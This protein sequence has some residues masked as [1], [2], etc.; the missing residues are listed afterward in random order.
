MN[1]NY[2][3]L[4]AAICMSCGRDVIE[5]EI[6]IPT[7]PKY[8]EASTRHFEGAEIYVIEGD[9]AVTRDELHAEYLRLVE[10][11]TQHNR[12]LRDGIARSTSAATINV[13]N[14][15]IDRWP[16][17]AAR[18]LTYCVSDEFGGLK[19]RAL[20]EMAQAGA[21][22]EAVAEVDFRYVPG[23]DANCTG[24]NAGV[25]FAVRPWT[26]NGACAFFP[27]GYGCV[28]RTVLMNFN[29]FNGGNITS[30]GAFRHELG[31][32]LGL[33]HEHVRVPSAFCYEDSNWAPLT[34]YDSASVMHYPWCPGGTNTGDYVITALDAAGVASI[35]PPTPFSGSAITNNNVG[36]FAGWSA[37]PGV[38]ALGGDFNAD[39]LGDIALVGGPGWVSLPVAFG[40]GAGGFSTI[41]NYYL[42]DYPAMAASA[43]NIVAADFDADGDTDIAL[44]GGP[45]NT[46]P[47]AFSAGNGSFFVVAHAVPNIPV[48]GQQTGARAIAGDFDG[49]GDGDIALSGAPWASIPVAFSNRDGTF[50]VT[51]YFV[52]SFPGWAST[53]GAQ[54]VGGDFDGDGDTDLALSGVAG[55][56]SVPVAFSQGNGGFSVTNGFFAD[57]PGWAATPGAKLIAG[58]FDADGDAD[59]AAPGGAGLSHIPFALSSRNGNFTP[60][61]FFAED[62]PG[63]ATAARRVIARR[64]DGDG[65]ADIVLAGGD[66]WNTMPVLMLRP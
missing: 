32:V 27:H 35:Y 2:L 5:E 18:N 54:I 48:W 60:V 56:G 36:S 30:L 44:V 4:Y 57:F 10:G 22:W 53:G 16:H 29:A 8:L 64:I 52:D 47:I 14:G 26:D 37:L 9:L 51:N 46:V 17:N 43:S 65:S 45:W 62:F 23:H 55:W 50:Y 63:W 39:G 24:N 40:D 13:Y 21:G 42:A 38:R 33:R 59:L 41:T 19:S 1:R 11:T 12:D 28:A 61:S 7:W 66:G 25:T 34:T 58:D 15:A 3:F 20:T 6:S 31:H 49:D